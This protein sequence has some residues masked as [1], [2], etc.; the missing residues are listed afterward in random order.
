[1]AK[2][3]AYRPPA[4]RKRRDD[5]SHGWRQEGQ[6]LL[7]GFAGGAIV[8]MPLLYTMEMWWH[9]MTLSEWHLLS[10]LGALLLVNT[11]F[12]LFVGL[13]EEHTLGGAFSDAITSLGIALLFSAAVLGLIGE[14]RGG[15][16]LAESCGKILIEAVGVSV[17]VSF[18]NAYRGRSRTGEEEQQ[19]GGGQD[20]AAAARRARREDPEKLQLQADLNDLGA[21]LAGAALFAL[22]IAPTE[23]VIL[24]ASRLSPWQQFAL[25]AATFGLCYVILFAAGFEA[26]QV[27][28]DSV[29]QHPLAE[30]V[31]A[32]A[33]SL[34]VALFLLALLGQREVLSHPS[35]AIAATLTLGLPAAVG[36]AAGRLIV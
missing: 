3:I 19:G 27:H 35:S 23:E 16:A 17:G 12:S 32:C 2:T 14:L 34:G 9:G 25:L 22:N 5:D 4:A 36:G 10:L 28:V 31:M 29:F 1:V 20:G 8:G 11:L 24:I 13:R 21:T 6:D 26:H 30:T 7:R 15:A 33:T 18:A